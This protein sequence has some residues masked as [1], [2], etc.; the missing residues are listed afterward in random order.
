MHNTQFQ[1]KV[2]LGFLNGCGG[3]TH[4]YVGGG[5]VVALSGYP[6]RLERILCETADSVG[7]HPVN[8]I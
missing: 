7:I 3:E 6:K 2:R 4:T 5:G 1:I 8:K